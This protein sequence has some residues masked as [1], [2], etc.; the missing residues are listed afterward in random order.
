[1]TTSLAQRALVRRV[2]CGVWGMRGVGRQKP[3]RP[4]KKMTRR[5]LI[6][7]C[8]TL[9]YFTTFILRHS[10]CTTA[11]HTPYTL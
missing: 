2:G 9:K 8:T 7:T 5:I 10:F 4:L 11:V 6:H 1:M 3:R